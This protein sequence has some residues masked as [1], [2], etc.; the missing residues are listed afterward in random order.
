MKAQLKMTETIMVLIIF[1]F[2]LVFG[3]V[4]YAR[5]A[6]TENN[7]AA[8]EVA[9]LIALQISQKVQ[10]MPEIQCT[11]EGTID[12]NCVDILKLEALKGIGDRE[13]LIYEKL[14]PNTVV[15]ITQV[16][17]EEKS[18]DV[19]GSAPLFKNVRR[20]YIPVAL[21]DAKID[22]TNMGFMEIAVYTK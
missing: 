10:F 15:K 2:L 1:L 4:V 12:F 21:Y 5:W 17:P 9:S 19:Y 7:Q 11:T 22:Q 3:L 13:R 20:F 14:F 16:Y 6:K 8:N 18:W